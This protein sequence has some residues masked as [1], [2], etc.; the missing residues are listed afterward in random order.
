MDIATLPAWERLYVAMQVGV[1]DPILVERLTAEARAM[2]DPE[3][4]LTLAALLAVWVLGSAWGGPA[5]WA[6]DAGVAAMGLFYLGRDALF[7]GR[8]MAGFIEKGL[9]AKTEADIK[10]AGH[11]FAQGLGQ[12]G[13]TLVMGLLGT[14]AFKA[15]RAQWVPKLKSALGR[16]GAIAGEVVGEGAVRER[17][18][19]DKVKDTAKKAGETA[20][21]VARG[22]GLAKTAEGASLGLVLVPLAVL[23]AAGVG[24]LVLSNRKSVTVRVEPPTAA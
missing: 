22:T 2:L 17:T 12:L 8:A 16:G 1:K 18:G 10:A 3:S 23:A 5:A 15:V 6:V 9:A 4:L 13:S 7:V 20:L 14:A 19:L 21:D 24:I 11:D